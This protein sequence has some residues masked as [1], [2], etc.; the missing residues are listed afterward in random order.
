MTLKGYEISDHD[1]VEETR[2]VSEVTKRRKFHETNWII[3]I[4]KMPFGIFQKAY[5]SLRNGENT[6]L[7]DFFKISNFNPDESSYC[8]L[9]PDEAELSR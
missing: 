5:L 2:F 3:R 4:L 8:G 1:P 7:I 9:V 6:Y